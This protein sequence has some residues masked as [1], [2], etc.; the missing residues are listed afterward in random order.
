MTT[1]RMKKLFFFFVAETFVIIE[2]FVSF[3]EL[4]I[5]KIYFIN[6]I[7]LVNKIHQVGTVVYSIV[8]LKHLIL[9]SK[10]CSL[11]ESAWFLNIFYPSKVLNS[12]I[13]RS[14]KNVK[15]L[16]YVNCGENEK[17]NYT[18]YLALMTKQFVIMDTIQ[19]NL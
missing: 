4:Y 8:N 6:N 2:N 7:H 1:K 14:Q 13:R 19:H 11:R 5:F 15:L 18:I 16:K 12:L 9:K 10:I 3:M 17:Y